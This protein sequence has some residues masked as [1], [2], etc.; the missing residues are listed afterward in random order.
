MTDLIASYEA[1]MRA[2]G[3]ARNTVVDRVEL[4]RRINGALPLGLAHATT[5]ELAAWLAH[6]GWSRQ[7]RATYYGHIRGFYAYH[8]NPSRRVVLDWDP[9]AGLIRPRAPRGVPRPVTDEQ[10]TY[11][12]AHI[13][14]P[15]E[16]YV[17]LAAYAGLRSFE[18]ATLQRADVNERTI[19]V[20]D[21]K[22]GRSRVI[23]THWLIWDA[24]RLRGPGLIA[25]ATSS[26]RMYADL[27]SGL[28]A[29]RA[30]DIGLVGFTLHRCRHWYGTMLLRPKDEGG[31][32][33]NLRAVQELLGH[34]SPLTT[35]IYTLVTD[36]Q[37]RN[38]V[39]ALPALAP[40][41]R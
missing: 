36:E 11:A 21:G 35:A 20:V 34:A 9:S 32:G 30:R 27:I 38:A 14:R 41:P 4:L 1:H 6:D 40:A 25:R 10:L 28:T 24:V 8:C 15:W 17:L 31:A 2:A 5:E 16:T 22:G 19:T 13:G 3:Y 18:I 39:A 29:K 33:A 23:P 26:G 37:R 7:T 12:L